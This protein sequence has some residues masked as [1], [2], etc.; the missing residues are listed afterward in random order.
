MYSTSIF[1]A[2]QQ[3]APIYDQGPQGSC[4]ENAI[5]A[6]VQNLLNQAG[7]TVAPA[8]TLVADLAPMQYAAPSR[9][10]LY[11][12][13]LI[14]L[15]QL[16]HDVGSVP[17][18]VYSIAQ[19]TGAAPEYDMPYDPQSISVTPSARALADASAMK[20]TSIQSLPEATTMS[21]GGLRAVIMHALEEG[22]E[23]QVSFVAHSGIY[24]ETTTNLTYDNTTP[25][26]GGHDV[27]IVGIHLDKATGNSVIEFQNSWSTGWGADGYGEMT[28]PQL[29]GIGN[30]GAGKYWTEDLQSM[31]IITGVSVNGV[32]IDT[33][34]TPG[35]VQATEAYL[36]LGR[37]G[38][39]GGLK[40]WGRAF[41]Q[42]FTMKSVVG[43]LMASQEGQALYAGDS[44]THLIDQ[45]YLNL[46]G[47]VADTGGEAFWVH[48][49]DLGIAPSDVLFYMM[50]GATGQDVAALHNRSLVVGNGALT[51]QDSGANHSADV[52][53]LVGVNSVYSTVVSAE[54]TLHQALYGF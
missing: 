7:Y 15:H 32:N 2:T 23:I 49:L 31:N 27:N 17:A 44:H 40:Y 20:I 4:V 41:D 21:A 35:R 54:S 43:M 3:D 22:H 34:W 24:N 47:R 45:F 13:N 14:A 51:F 9:Q 52:A 26:I 12:E 46:F 33:E 28:V 1:Y 50:G 48:A 8:G 30:Q 10:F 25:V 16:G 19:N 29:M 39:C 11:N 5:C 37:T 53:A 6:G 38:D 42:G 18:T 36:A